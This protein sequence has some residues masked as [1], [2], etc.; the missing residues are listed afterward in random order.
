MNHIRT[1]AVAIAIAIATGTINAAYAQDAVEDDN[2]EAS[3]DIIV[4]ATRSQS[5]ASKTPVALSAVSGEQLTAAG[6]SN[7]TTLA[8]QVPNLS[9]DRANGL[10]ITIRGVSSSDGTE[11]G[12]PSAAF[13]V[14]GIYIARPQVQEVSFFDIAR[15]EVLRGPQG[16]LF[17]RN[18]TAGLVNIIANKPSVSGFSGSVDATYGNYDTRQLTGV[19]NLPVSD[20][21][22]VRAAANYDYRDST[23]I[24]GP[25]FDASLDP[26]KNNLS[27]RLSALFNFG[28]GSLLLRGDYSRM[29]GQTAN[30]LP[31][32]NFYSN[33]AT[34]GSTPIYN[35]ADKSADDLMTF[36]LPFSGSLDR[37]NSTWGVL[38]D[39]E[40]DLGPV[41][42][43]YLGSYREF[44]RDEQGFVIVR[45]A[46]T[47]ANDFDGSYWQTSH[48]LRFSAGNAGPLKVQAGVYYFKEKSAIGYYIFGFTS[49]TPGTRGYTRGFPQDPTIAE[50]KALFGQATYSLTDTLRVTGGV[51]YSHDEKSRVGF[52]VTC[53]TPACDQAG[54]TLAPNNAQGTFSKVTWRAGLDY[55]L[56]SRSLLYA[57]VSTGYK[58]GGFNDGCEVGTA[59]GCAQTRDALYYQPEELTAY[60]VGLKTRFADNRVRLN[61]SA[62]HYDY[63]N[64]QLSQLTQLCGGPCR[65]TTNAGKAKVDGVEAE[66]VI[67]PY[68][69]G[70]LDLSVAWLDAR[71]TE[72]LLTPTDDWAGRALDRSPEW[73]VAAGYT[74]QINLANG[75]NIQLGART[76]VSDSY[77]IAALGTANQFRVPSYTKTDVQV[78]YNAPDNRWYLQAFAKNLENSIVV[79]S[80][81]TGSF[82]YITVADPRTYGVR[83]GIK[84]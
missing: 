25:A 50:S 6:I 4:T 55:D 15:V 76:R 39:F 45:S 42:V 29:R 48:E 69:G 59:P 78:A 73:V 66:S 46:G 57:V 52:S 7:P 63:T 13:M 16:T 62:F 70:K 8:E 58:A 32:S 38:G 21:I 40:Y 54:D 28:N 10:Q 75:G 2:Y 61:L 18:T 71:F 36:G 11:K 35:G 82:A 31:V 33:Y 20:N 1:S 19:V 9:I 22:A 77:Q 5:L 47:A 24:A 51:R 60:E 44:D 27:G 26:Y 12:D 65:V 49:P 3:G 17:G 80:A 56:D 72:F 79:T 43:N 81:S 41:T 30:I 74:H 64:I 23:M 14:D 34:S 67:E 53:Q 84:F 37:R 83:A 68:D